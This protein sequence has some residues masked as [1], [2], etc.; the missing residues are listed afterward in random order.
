MHIMKQRGDGGTSGRRWGG[1]ASCVAAAV[2]SEAA[3]GA[4]RARGRQKEL[5]RKDKREVKAHA[6]EHAPSGRASAGEKVCVW[7]MTKIGTDTRTLQKLFGTNASRFGKRNVLTPPLQPVPTY[8]T[9]LKKTSD[10]SKHL[11][12][13]PEGAM[14]DGG[15]QKRRDVSELKAL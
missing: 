14:S 8:H 10:P 3:T 4:Q 13:P 15:R 5:G 2:R 6:G 1:G 7:E 11:R 9:P 12:T